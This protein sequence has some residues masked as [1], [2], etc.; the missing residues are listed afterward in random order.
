VD[1]A[2]VNVPT[3]VKEVKETPRPTWL[4]FV[5]I[6]VCLL[7]AL[8]A[9]LLWSNSKPRPQPLSRRLMLAVLP[10]ENLTGDAGQDYFSDG[11]TEEMIAQLGHLDPGHLGVMTR[12]SV[13]HYKNG[14]ARL[15]QISRDLAAQ[16]FLG[17]RVPR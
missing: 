2:E 12:T 16:Y 5:G 6:A 13:R 11:M 7:A 14:H 8:G 15:A 1:A 4:A 9:H 17:G 3:S 10:F